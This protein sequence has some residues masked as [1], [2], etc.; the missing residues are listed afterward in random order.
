MNSSLRADWA[1]LIDDDVIMR[2]RIMWLDARS[3]CETFLRQTN[4]LQTDERYPRRNI[5][6]LTKKRRY[7]ETERNDVVN[8]VLVE[9]KFLSS[10]LSYI[11][12]R[13]FRFAYCFLPLLPYLARLVLKTQNKT[14]KRHGQSIKERDIRYPS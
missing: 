5:F 12:I 14:T 11:K 1:G 8:H 6:F 10:S 7:C 13:P 3:M 4:D 2:A 9:L